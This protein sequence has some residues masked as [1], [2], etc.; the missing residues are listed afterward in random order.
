[1]LVLVACVSSA[2]GDTVSLDPVARAADATRSQR[3]EHVEL[4][5][6]L[7]AGARQIQMVGSGDF[8]NDPQVGDF[9]F[10]IVGGAGS[11]TVR[12]IMDGSMLYLSSPLLAGR[13]PGGK[14][15]ISF[16]FRKAVKTLGVDMQAM[17]TESPAQ[18]LDRLRRTG[19]VRSVGTD[20]IDGARTT[21][22]VATIDPS[23][24]SGASK[25]EQLA[26]VTYEPVDVWVD[27]Q[28][29]VRRMRLAYA[30]AAGGTAVSTETTMEFARYGEPVSVHVPSAAETFDATDAV[31]A[32]RGSG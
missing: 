10:R 6:T 4:V 20:V 32:L 15:W 12:E 24:L 30:A 28:G 23:K 17:A 13:L 5:S 27:A 18:A 19:T 26:D 16:D 9:T 11:G 22:Y 8:Q 7:A 3:S 14:S 1:M 2:C 31:Q 29:L 25:L 21:H